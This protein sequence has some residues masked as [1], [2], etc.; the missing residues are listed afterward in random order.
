[1]IIPTAAENEGVARAGGWGG[2]IGWGGGEGW[3][4]GDQL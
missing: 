2:G 1:M 4:Q 3:K